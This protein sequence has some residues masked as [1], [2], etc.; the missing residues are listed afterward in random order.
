MRAGS[1]P[2]AESSLFVHPGKSPRTQRQLNL[3]FYFQLLKSRI[4]GKNY[5]NFVEFGCGR[6][7]LSEYLAVYLGKKVTLLDTDQN[8]LELVRTKFSS[9][10]HLDFHA[11]QADALDCGL[12]SDNYC[13]ATSIGLAEHFH[14]EDEITQFFSEQFRVLKP[15]GMVFS[16]NIPKKRLGAQRLNTLNRFI[17]RLLGWYNGPIKKD[18][19]RNNFSATVYKKSAERAGFCAVEVMHVNPYPIYVPLSPSADRLVTFL[20]LLKLKVRGL[21][22]DYAFAT[23]P[24][25]GTAHFVIGYKP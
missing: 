19:Y 12:P 13:V 22:C 24:I 21:F 17:Q 25:L 5:H 10:P 6:G 8:A 7:T 15:G 18:Y 4:R 16:L 9:N 20:R 14:T 11:F 3:Y 2:G 23:N 1:D